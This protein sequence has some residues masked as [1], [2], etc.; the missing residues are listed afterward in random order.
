MSSFSQTTSNARDAK[1]I[2]KIA[3][4]W[5]NFSICSK[6]SKKREKSD[7]ICIDHV[8]VYNGKVGYAKKSVGDYKLE[9]PNPTSY[10]NSKGYII[11]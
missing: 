2:L 4:I 9:N 5:E 11:G 6:N 8:E 3:E 7:V 10:W 1:N